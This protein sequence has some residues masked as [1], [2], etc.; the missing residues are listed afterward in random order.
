MNLVF[1]DVY[2]E[3]ETEQFR[4]KRFPIDRNFSRRIDGMKQAFMYKIIK[5]YIKKTDETSGESTRAD[6]T[7]NEKVFTMK[8]EPAKV[9]ASTNKYKRENDKYKSFIDF[10]LA[11]D[12]NKNVSIAVAEVYKIYKDWLKNLIQMQNLRIN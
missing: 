3:T 11:K 5:R 10:R 9:L 12:P 7:N 2:P 4:Q 8:T 1:N 6:G